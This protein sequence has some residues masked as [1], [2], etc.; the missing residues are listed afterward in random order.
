MRTSETGR[1]AAV[2]IEVSK[3]STSSGEHLLL[4]TRIPSHQ[5]WLGGLPVFCPSPSPCCG[6]IAARHTTHHRP[7]HGWVTDGVLLRPRGA[8]TTGVGDLDATVRGVA[9]LAGRA[10][11]PVGCP[12]YRHTLAGSPAVS[13]RARHRGLHGY[14]HNAAPTSTC[15]VFS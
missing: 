5:A 1:S 11:T 13:Q 3:Q 9:R 14:V 4:V 2:L 6:A 7:S 10:P 12:H 15:I 8:G